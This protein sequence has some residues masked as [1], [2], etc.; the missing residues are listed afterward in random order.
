MIAVSILKRFTRRKTTGFTLLEVLVVMALLSLVMLALG[1]ALRTVGQTQERI[2][3]RLARADELRVSEA[4]I[5]STLGRI[6]GRM[7]NQ[8][9]T[10]QVGSSRFMFAAAPNAVAWVGVMPARFGVGGRYF[11]RLAVETVGVDTAL[12]IRFKRWEDSSAFPDW[13]TADSRVLAANV[14]SL[15]IR[16]ENARMEPPA[17]TP[18]WAIAD[19]LPERVALDVQTAAGEWP[20]LVVPLRQLPRS[21]ERGD[22]FTVGGGRK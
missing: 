7:I 4:F 6:S 3:Q 8:P 11:F 15:S 1:S 21:D 9:A 10:A 2:D 19:R 17:W 20:A 16:Y 13:A 14:T 5:R 18:D 22:G 12:V